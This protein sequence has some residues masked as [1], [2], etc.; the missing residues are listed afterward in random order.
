MYSKLYIPIL[1]TVCKN[2]GMKNVFKY[3]NQ[4]NQR[5]AETLTILGILFS[6]KEPQFFL[7]IE[8]VVYCSDKRLINID[9]QLFLPIQSV[10]SMNINLPIRKLL[11]STNQCLT[12]F[13]LQFAI[14]IKQNGGDY[15][16]KKLTLRIMFFR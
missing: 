12:Y 13:Y 14:C 6:F 1:L 16:L 7:L 11:L 10:V 5:S 15:V 8:F 9:I 3:L 4:L 2:I